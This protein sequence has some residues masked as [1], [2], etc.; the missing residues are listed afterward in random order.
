MARR[1]K[2][3]P[4]DYVIRIKDRGLISPGIAKAAWTAWE[5]IQKTAGG[6]APVPDACPG[7]S[8]Q[9]LFTWDAG[10]HH[11]ELEIT[12]AEELEFFYWDRDTDATW[13]HDCHLDQPIPAAV[14]DALRLFV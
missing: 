2:N 5:G 8:G 4:L 1:Y 9:L 11:L 7:P 3:P 13:E 10:Q 6:Q 12:S 14:L